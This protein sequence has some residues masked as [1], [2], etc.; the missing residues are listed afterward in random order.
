MPSTTKAGA[1]Q[2]EILKIAPSYVGIRETWGA[3]K[4]PEV[5]EILKRAGSTPGQPWCMSLVYVINADAAKNIGV[6]NQVPRTASSSVY[7]IYANKHKLTFKVTP[8]SQVLLGKKIV[9]ASTGIFK[10]GAYRKD[11]TFSGH[12]NV[13]M[14]QISKRQYRGID[15]NTSETDKTLSQQ[16]EGGSSS[17]KVRTL[18]VPSFLVMGFIEVR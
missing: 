16:W 10:H 4:G 15:G 6:K 14:G 17:Y 9:P 3:N 18:G 13:V 12:A 1:L 8:A 11:G 2:E 5:N 7:W